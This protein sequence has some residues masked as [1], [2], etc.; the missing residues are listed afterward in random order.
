MSASPQ[1]TNENI[2]SPKGIQSQ[3]LKGP[4]LPFGYVMTFNGYTPVTSPSTIGPLNYQ[5]MQISSDSN[6]EVIDLMKYDTGGGNGF[7]EFKLN[8]G[9]L[10]FG[11]SYAGQMQGYAGINT[12][13]GN[14]MFPYV[15]K[16]PFIFPA[17]RVITG[18]YADTTGTG[19][20]LYLL[21]MG[22]KV[23]PSDSALSGSN[24]IV[25]NS[26]VNST[27]VQYPVNF[28]VT[29]PG[30]AY[31]ASIT[32]TSLQNFVLQGIIIDDTNTPVLLNM[33]FGAFGNKALFSAAIPSRMISGTYGT[34]GNTTGVT[35]QGIRTFMLPSY[36]NLPSQSE[37]N[38]T[39]QDFLNRSDYFVNI[40]LVGVTY[41]QATGQ[42]E[43]VTVPVQQQPTQ[44]QPVPNSNNNVKVSGYGF[45]QVNNMMRRW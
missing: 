31:S 5:Q 43:Q 2:F 29:S 7:V 8:D 24:L 38:I 20:N 19:G 40:M 25:Q 18:T 39:I 23:Y 42:T 37:I 16:K 26:L 14:G 21:F 15:F 9:T 27:P 6:F 45:N 17:T 22:N 11:T 33:T 12:M 34:N 35:A 1:N 30:Q 44:G 3:T 10:F 13:F 32:I 41:N 28:Y 36:I 4:R